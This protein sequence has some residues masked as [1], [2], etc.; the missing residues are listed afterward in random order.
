MCDSLPTLFSFTT[1]FIG[2]KGVLRK[3]VWA[4]FG[5]E[6]IPPNSDYLEV[7]LKRAGLYPG[8]VMEW[9]HEAFGSE[10]IG[11]IT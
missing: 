9:I 7:A 8:V 3:F 1:W 5:T 4:A 10:A 2:R 11:C 6:C